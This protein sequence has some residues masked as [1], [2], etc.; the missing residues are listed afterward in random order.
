MNGL[1]GLATLVLV[2]ILTAQPVAGQQPDATISETGRLRVSYISELTPIGINT[3]H[4]WRLHVEEV[5]G[6][7]VEKA[8]ISV[9]GGMSEHDHGL[10]TIPLMTDYLGNGD[11]LLEGM[12]FH[13]NGRWTVTVQIVQGQD[14]DTAVFELDL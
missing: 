8:E 13:M 1:P 5:A 4:S 6:G 11:Y 3:M 7:V 9:S 2:V 12:K 10:P 14:I